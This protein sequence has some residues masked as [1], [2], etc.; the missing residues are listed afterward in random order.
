MELTYEFDIAAD[1]DNAWAVLIDVPRIAPCLPGAK[2]T[3]V[4]GDNQYQGT[5]SVKLGPVKL[6]FAGEAELFDVDNDA[7]SA[8]MRAK[9]SDK[10]GRGTANA[11]VEFTL[12]A[13]EDGRTRIAVRADLMLAGNIAQ[14]GRAS[15]L[16]DQMAQQIISAFVENL[17]AEM[18]SDAAQIHPALVS[19]TEP[20]S[21]RSAELIAETIDT[22]QIQGSTEPGQNSVSDNSISGLSLLFRALAEIIKGWFSPRKNA[23]RKQ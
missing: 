5:A 3:E 9:G 6:S 15:G 17:E 11:D 20:T 1:L 7:H 8:K 10:K 19:D 16:I 2:L 18:G 21:V 13:L 14:Y 23:G 22:G 12:N 4:V